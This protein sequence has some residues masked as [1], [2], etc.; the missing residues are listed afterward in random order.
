M[1][2]P[3]PSARVS[4]LELFFDLVFVFTITQVAHLVAHAHSALDLTKAFLILTIAWW[5]YG[6][7]VWLTN[8]LGTTGLTIRLLLLAGMAAYFVMA[9]SI[10]RA[11]GP[12]GLAFALSYLVVTGVHAVLFTHA[13][14]TSALAILKIAPFNLIGALFVVAA[15]VVGP[16]WSWLGW[17]VAV[18]TFVGASLARRERGFHVNASHFAER[19]ALVTI[20]AIG[21]SLVSI[22]VGSRRHSRAISAHCRGTPGIRARSG[23]LV[24][25]LRP[26]R[27]AR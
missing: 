27:C 14:N 1:Q 12:D 5:M 24:V 16:R 10:P 17:L 8:N 6:G 7:Y 22:G 2:G 21:E 3:A 15:A 11:D 4:T 13:P 23:N 20:V 25:L 9:L 26:G 18:L 19:H